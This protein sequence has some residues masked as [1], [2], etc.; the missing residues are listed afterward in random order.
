M[1]HTLREMSSINGYAR[2]WYVHR[3]CGHESAFNET[4]EMIKGSG[5]GVKFADGPTGYLSCKTRTKAWLGQ[6]H[7]IKNLEKKYCQLVSKRSFLRCQETVQDKVWQRRKL[8]GSRRTQ[9]LQLGSWPFALLLGDA[10]ETWHLEEHH[11]KYVWC[12][13]SG[14]HGHRNHEALLN[15]AG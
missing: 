6:P 2:R 13:H 5:F 14:T 10:F 7:L 11:R 8:H 12:S 9:V 1:P 4:I 3:L 15:S